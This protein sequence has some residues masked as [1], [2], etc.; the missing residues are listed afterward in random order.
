[1]IGNTWITAFAIKAIMGFGI[2]PQ[3]GMVQGR[4]TDTKGNPIAGVR[5]VVENTVFHASYTYG[6]TNKDGYYK[7]AVPNGSW[8]VTAQM[9]REFLGR[10]YR[11][12]LHPDTDDDFAGTKGAI[13]NFTWK[14]SG[15]KP[16]NGGY[17]G[18]SIGVYSQPGSEFSMEE[19]QLTLTPDGPLAD[20]SKGNVITSKLTDIGGG[21]DGIR[22]IPIGKYIIT[23]TNT[24][25]GKRLQVRQRNKGDYGNSF[26]AIFESGFT[27]AY[28][29]QVVVQVK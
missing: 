6:I 7:T 28:H 10:M 17:Y 16:R 26:S 11:F 3:K 20:G 14:L 15:A 24:T 19:V 1:M 8:H 22:D 9:Q 5:V 29:Y 23:A 4:V 13:R 12:E 27:G 21:E 25:T 18:S 2:A